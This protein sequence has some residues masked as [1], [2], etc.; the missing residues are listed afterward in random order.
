MFRRDGFSRTIRPG[1]TTAMFP[2][3]SS[4]RPN[5]PPSAWTEEK[6]CLAQGHPIDDLEIRLPAAAAYA[7]RARGPHPGWK[8]VVNSST[9]RV[10][11]CHIFRRPCQRDRADGR[12]RLAPGCHQGGFRPHH[13]LASDCGGRVGDDADEKLFEKPLRSS[14]RLPSPRR[15]A[16]CR[17]PRCK[18]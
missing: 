17:A 18:G 1:R 4:P 15:R 11:G 10:L 8:L 12:Y 9:A 14:A 7:G 2:A 6:A 16:C 5:W 3:L 13:R